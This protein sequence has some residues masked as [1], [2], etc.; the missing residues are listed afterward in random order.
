MSATKR[1]N[2]LDWT[3]LAAETRESMMHVGALLSFTPPADATPES[4]RKLMD[5]L[6]ADATAYPP[7]SLKLKH[8]NFLASPL[9]AWIEDTNFDVEYHVRRSA[10]PSPGD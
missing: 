7:W 3:F 8:P 2:P 5:E 6:R 1:L 10:L 4:L 9:Q